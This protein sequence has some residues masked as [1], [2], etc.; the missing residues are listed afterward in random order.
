M[1]YLQEAEQARAYMTAIRRQI[2][3]NPE[4]SWQEHETAQLICGELEKLG[5][6]CRRAA[7]TGVV[8]IIEGP[9]GAPC[10]GLRADMDALPITEQNDVVYKSKREGVM[11]ACG[12]DAHVAILLG[13][14]RIL[15]QNRNLLQSGVKLIFQPAEEIIA[16]AAV[17]SKEPLLAD[18]ANVGA[19]HVWLTLPV[20]AISVMPGTRMASA[21]TFKIKV[22]GAGAH[23]SMPHLGVDSVYVAS[24]MVNAIQHVVARRCDPLQ[25][26][27][28]TVGSIRAGTAGNILAPGAQMEGTVRTF[29]RQLRRDI[30]VWV[31]RI[32]THVAAAFDAAAT[33]E[34]I[35][36]TPPLVNDERSVAC[37]K[38]CAEAVVGAEHVVRTEPTTIA[39]DFAYFL[40]KVPGMLAFVGGRNEKKGICHPHHHERF[41]LDEDALVYGAAFLARYAVEI[42]KTL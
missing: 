40:E 27:V 26:T 10:I 16:G 8:G 36:G 9:P 42:G 23:G 31:E 25:P 19:L 13:A 37:A 20:G 1:Q 29:D 14:A 21:D 41:E 5:V 24:M 35:E 11:H 2:H 22:Q 32:V 34:L 38:A 30:P 12:H 3:M 18:L 39:E 4:L 7:G 6:P 28:V 33:F 15:V 17:L